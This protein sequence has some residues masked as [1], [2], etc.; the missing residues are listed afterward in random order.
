MAVELPRADDL[1]VGLQWES[2]KRLKEGSQITGVS[3]MGSQIS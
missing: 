1:V 3:L 2:W